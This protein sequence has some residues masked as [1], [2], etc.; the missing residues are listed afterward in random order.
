[1]IGATTQSTKM[2]QLLRKVQPCQFASYQE[3]IRALMLEALGNSDMNFDQLNY[4]L[5]EL[6]R[7]IFH[8]VNK[9]TSAF[10]MFLVNKRPDIIS[11]GSSD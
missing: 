6:N 1:M 11:D 4:N 5:Y 8:K 2:E 7:E 10:Y 3:F 9:E